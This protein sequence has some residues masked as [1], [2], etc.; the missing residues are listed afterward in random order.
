MSEE[1]AVVNWKRK[2]EEKFRL[3]L[4]TLEQTSPSS[5]A[6]LSSHDF[7]EYYS[8]NVNFIRSSIKRN[9]QPKEYQFLYYRLD[10]FRIPRDTKDDETKDKCDDGLNSKRF[11]VQRCTHCDS[12][13]IEFD[14]KLSSIVC[15]ACGNTEYLENSSLVGCDEEV[16]GNVYSYKRENHFLGCL[17][18][19]CNED[20]VHIP[21][22]IIY[23]VKTFVTEKSVGA[24][25]AYLRTKFKDFLP[26]HVRIHAMI[27]GEEHPV[28][29][30]KQKETLCGL[31]ARIQAPFAKLRP[32]ERCNFL[33]YPYVAY[34]LLEIAGFHNF[35]K[36]ITLLKSKAKIMAQEEMFRGICERL[37]WEFKPLPDHLLKPGAKV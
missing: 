36:Y 6:P 31:F 16:P 9:R 37:N 14:T 1:S 25:K 10:A 22:N 21:D 27:L 4:E 24:T 19:F 13:K 12:E 17:K 2:A 15:K 34:K 33:S 7:Q 20:I 23:E 8:A 26:Y 32:K 18:Y 11:Q 3:Y 5:R 29:T 35:L 28:L 30:E